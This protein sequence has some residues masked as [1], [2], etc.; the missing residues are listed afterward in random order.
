MQ[1]TPTFSN[2]VY[3]HSKKRVLLLKYLEKVHSTKNSALILVTGENGVGKT[4]F[5]LTL[6]ELSIQGTYFFPA[7]NLKQS[8]ESLPYE[9]IYQIINRVIDRL[10]TLNPQ[11]KLAIEYSLKVNLGEDLYT[12]VHKIPKITALFSTL[13]QKKYNPSRSYPENFLFIITS[14][15]KTIVTT[16]APSPVIFFLDDIQGI[17][18]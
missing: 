3:G 15:F 14:A 11:K 4:S 13:P 6:D 5:V 1:K 9:G 16:L 18:H 8:D 7:T 10:L 12:L 2:K 17:D